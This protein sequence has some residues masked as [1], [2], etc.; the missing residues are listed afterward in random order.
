MTCFDC[1]II[2]IFVRMQ[3]GQMFCH[4]VLNLFVSTMFRQYE[5]S[6]SGLLIVNLFS[7]SDQI[8]L[9]NNIRVK[10]VISPFF[11]PTS[12]HQQNQMLKQR[13]QPCFRYNVQKYRFNSHLVFLKYTIYLTCITL[14]DNKQLFQ[15][16]KII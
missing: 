15:I 5:S 14:Q 2:S 12:T 11:L 4:V 1:K 16:K 9:N 3:L 13:K 10:I 7:I 8:S 6:V